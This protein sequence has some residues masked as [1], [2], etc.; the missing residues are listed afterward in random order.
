MNR[1]VAI[2]HPTAA[3]TLATVAPLSILAT[4]RGAD[5]A[6]GLVALAVVVSGAL[7]RIRPAGTALTVALLIVYFVYGSALDTPA[8]MA[9]SVALT[10]AAIAYAGYAALASLGNLSV[11]GHS[12]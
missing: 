7:A 6:I 12:P 2:L 4:G 3:T 8:R 5:A 11:G 10:G 9:A 1:A